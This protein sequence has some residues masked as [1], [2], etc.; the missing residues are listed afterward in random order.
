MEPKLPEDIYKTHLENTSEGWYCSDVLRGVDVN[1]QD[2]PVMW[3]RL[4]KILHH[5]LSMV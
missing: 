3:T 2:S 1:V 4:L 5:H